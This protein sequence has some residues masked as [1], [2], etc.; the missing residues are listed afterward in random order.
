MRKGRISLK[1]K[2][3]E[4]N[5]EQAKNALFY[6]SNIGCITE[7]IIKKAADEKGNITFEFLANFEKLEYENEDKTKIIT[8]V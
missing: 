3:S 2:G 5:I 8:I 4:E 1:F 6:L 7:P